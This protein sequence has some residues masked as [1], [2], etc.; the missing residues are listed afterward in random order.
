MKVHINHS[1]KKAIAAL[2]CVVVEGGYKSLA[3]GCGRSLPWSG[4]L[5]AG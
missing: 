5:D 4:D 1:V 3:L 2:N